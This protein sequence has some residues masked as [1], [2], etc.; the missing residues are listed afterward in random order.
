[1]HI[2]YTIAQGA[3]KALTSR[4]AISKCLEK[5]LMSKQD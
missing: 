2:Q 3:K 1:M 4:K 5:I